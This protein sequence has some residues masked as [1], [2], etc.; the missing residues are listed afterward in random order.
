VK[1]FRLSILLAVC[2]SLS[3]CGNARAETD[4]DVSAVE[5]SPPASA[6][7]FLT[8]L[9][10]ASEPS[11]FESAIAQ[12]NVELENRIQRLEAQLNQGSQCVQDPCCAIEQRLLQQECGSGG[13][14][15]AVEVTFLKPAFSGAA[16]SVAVSTGQVISTHYQT[17]VRYIL[18]YANDSGLGVR[19]RYWSFNQN[20]LFAQPNPTAAELGIA[21]EAADTEVTLAQ[22]LRRWNLD[23]SGGLRYGKL[24]YSNPGLT[25]F[26]PGTVTFE[27]I[28][29]TAA[30]GL[31]RGLEN[32][33]FSLFGNARGSLMVG[34]IRTAAVLVNVPR[35]T[36]ED[37]VMTT[38]EN[39]FGVAWNH[40]FS[41][42]ML[43]EVR[44]AWESQY[45][46]N[47]L[48][49]DN[50]YGVGTNL[51]LMGPT[52]GVELRY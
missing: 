27:G 41:N 51:A 11:L 29:P 15:G 43:L 23:V 7:A 47:S 49:S 24:Q 40:Q 32:S 36:V 10:A 30:L 52:L 37:E 19:A 50:Y 35:G 44:T 34:D 39:Q 6:P 38:I 3:L 8:S 18:G 26:N 5:V 9:P 12:K 46:M 17:G 4:A 13:L 33:G 2:S 31:R 25:V 21:V 14:F 1:S 16:N 48:L 22:V 20:S 28:G 42:H 45:W